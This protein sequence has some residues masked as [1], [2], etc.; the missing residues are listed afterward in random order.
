MATE[1]LIEELDE[2][3]EHEL[4]RYGLLTYHLSGAD[5][6]EIGRLRG[7]YSE[8]SNADL[9]A[10]AA[11]K[12]TKVLLLTGDRRL[13]AAATKEKVPV[14]GTLWLLDELVRLEILAAPV[15]AESL[16]CSAPH[17]MI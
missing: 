2:P 13:R 15:A 4:K 3:D 5:I 14:R 11:A 9:S 16:N 1:F 7:Q 12:A 8:P 17:F 10:L 6:A